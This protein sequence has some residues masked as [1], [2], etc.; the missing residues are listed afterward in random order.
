MKQPLNLLSGSVTKSLFRFTVPILCTLLLQVMYGAADL[1]IVGQF[2][3]VPNASGVTTGSIVMMLVTNAGTGLATGV[4]I[5]IG[6]KIGER[7]RQ[8]LGTI[9]YNAILLFIL[10]SCAVMA[11]G[12]VFCD[13]IVGWMNTPADAITE[14]T[15]YL[16]ICFMGIPMIFAYN[17]LGSIFRGFGDSKTPMIAVAIACVLN[18]VIDLV[19]VAGFGMGAQG[20]AI[21]TVSAQ[22]ISVI[23][24]LVIAKKNQMLQFTMT[25]PERIVRPHY[26]RRY[27]KLGLPLAIQSV[28]TNFSFLAITM[29]VNQFGSVNSVAVGVAE[30]NVCL[31]MLLPIAFMQSL[32][33][34]VAQNV[35]AGQIER[36]KKGLH[37]SLAVS[38][39]FGLIMAY[40][41][42]FYG[43]RLATLFSGDT[44]VVA[45][46]AVYLK[47]YAIDTLLVPILFCLTGYF[48]GFGATTFTMVKSILGAVLLRI[49]LP[50]LFGAMEPFSLFRI[51][52]SIPIGSVF[53]IVVCMGF[54]IHFNRKYHGDPSILNV[55]R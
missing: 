13:T 10:L 42:F 36:A 2:S 55:V 51:G 48:N 40:F 17:V 21:A 16:T 37:S 9:V 38:F 39:A 6:Q 12:V 1:G 3:T 5:L 31:I 28:V 18:I 8:E 7:K 26:L 20:A 52:L 50:F 41:T 29:V 27:I 24:C 35:G 45:A 49:P 47:A 46:A 43:D 11:G 44:A 15:Q 4:T 32:S 23:L 19:L 33:V 30:K 54:Y 53:E 25:K 22:A 34:F 14:T